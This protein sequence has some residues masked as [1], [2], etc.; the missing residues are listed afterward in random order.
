MWKAFTLRGGVSKLAETLDF[1]ASAPT[2]YLLL[3]NQTGNKEGGQAQS[4]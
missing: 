3:F 4:N 2:A 1:I